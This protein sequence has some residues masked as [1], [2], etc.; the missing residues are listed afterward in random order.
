MTWAKFGTEFRDECA[1]AGLS[2]AAFR[3]HVEAI[4]YLYGIE[5]QDMRL[6]KRLMRRWAGSPEYIDAAAELA[7]IAWWRD[8]RDAYVVEHHANVI[9]QSIAA[10]TKH[11]D[12]ERERQQRKRAAEQAA[13]ARAAA[14]GD[15]GSDVGTNVGETQTDRQTDIHL[16]SEHVPSEQDNETEPPLTPSQESSSPPTELAPEDQPAPAHALDPEPASRA[17]GYIACPN[18]CG[19]FLHDNGHCNWCNLDFP[20]LAIA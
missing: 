12:D 1:E 7:R 13:R 9:R 19:T 2:D 8:D 5:S 14:A 18:G 20:E 6:Q 10:Q 3:T 15:V 17:P 11:R 16:G 4:Q